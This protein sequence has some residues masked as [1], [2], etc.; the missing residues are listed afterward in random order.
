MVEY[1]VFVYWRSSFSYTQKL[2]FYFLSNWMGY[3][4]GDSFP[5]DFEPNGFPFCSKSKGKLS[6][7]SYPIQCER[8]WKYSFVS[9]WF[10]LPHTKAYWFVAWCKVILFSAVSDHP[11]GFACEHESI[12][13]LHFNHNIEIKYILNYKSVYKIQTIIYSG[14]YSKISKGLF[15]ITSEP[16]EWSF[17]YQSYMG[18]LNNIQIALK[19]LKETGKKLKWIFFI[20]LGLAKYFKTMNQPCPVWPGTI[21]T[22]FDVLCFRR[23]ERYGREILIQS[24]CKSSIF[25]MKIWDRCN[26]CS[27]ENMRFSATY[28]FR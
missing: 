2:L 9:V 3:G 10:P 24:S 13:R 6:P 22:L 1:F 20:I 23:Y 5:F 14:F 8:N 17:N 21:V 16:S 4:R 11:L 15:I 26:F 7:R 19:P 25:A 28:Q 27:L 18:C 12:L